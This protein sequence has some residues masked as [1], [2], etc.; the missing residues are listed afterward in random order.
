MIRRVQPTKE[1]RGASGMTYRRRLL[2]LAD[3][4]AGRRQQDQS[5]EERP[6]RSASVCN[7]PQPLPRLMGFPVIAVVEEVETPRKMSEPSDA[8]AANGMASLL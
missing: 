6:K 2:A 8:S 3:L 1:R 5:L 7:L 4:H